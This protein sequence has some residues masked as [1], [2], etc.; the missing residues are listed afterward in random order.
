VNA[1]AVEVSGKICL[2][3][4]GPGSRVKTIRMRVKPK[5]L[6][7]VCLCEMKFSVRSRVK[8]MVSGEFVITMVMLKG[9][10]EWCF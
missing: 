5:F 4:S 10:R 2:C 7:G 1:R 3:V 6:E 8:A 9:E